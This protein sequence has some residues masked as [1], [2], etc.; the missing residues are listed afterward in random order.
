MSFEQW[1]RSEDNRVKALSIRKSKCED[2]VCSAFG[3]S[4]AANMSS[5]AFDHEVQRQ[6]EL[7]RRA[8]ME[9][10]IKHRVQHE[11]QMA[12]FYATMPYHSLGLGLGEK[13]D[14][15]SNHIHVS[16][17][18]FQCPTGYA[19]L[20]ATGETKLASGAY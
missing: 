15:V 16:G 10:E 11:M 20:G 13:R 6:V 2:Q 4:Y 12:S 19:A 3:S 14:D 8:F 5:A 1:Q 7:K 18:G 17:G 9:Q